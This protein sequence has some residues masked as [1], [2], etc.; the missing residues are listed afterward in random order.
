VDIDLLG[1][2]LARQHGLSVAPTR[3]KPRQ[4]LAMLALN[5][6]QAVPTS[7]MLEELWGH[8]LPRTAESTLHTYILQLRSLIKDALAQTPGA[9]PADVRR[10]IVTCPG[11]YLLNPMEGRTDVT[12]FDRLAVVGH[13]AHALGDFEAA[14][15]SFT[16]ALAMWRGRALVDVPVGMLLEPEAHRL[17]EAWLNALERRI[18]A[19]LRLG[20]HHELLGE[21]AG[22]VSRYRTHEGMHAHFM[23][24]LYRSGR[25]SEALDVYGRLR[26][27]LIS[28]LGLEP[29]PLLR[30]LHHAILVADPRLV[31][32]S[33]DLA[34]ALPAG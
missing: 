15:R 30:Q 16:K 31:E 21:L 10:I 12:V 34:S 27:Y 20:R 28:H 7:A 25:Q 6:H 4:V 29:S 17:E 13:R 19:D 32:Y 2:L 18:D 3:A 8:E 23:H 9:D 11:A 24:A 22:L 14:S 26:A 33:G 1:P 5:A